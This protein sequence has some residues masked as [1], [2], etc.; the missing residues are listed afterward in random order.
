MHGG[1]IMLQSIAREVPNYSVG[2]DPSLTSFGVYLRPIDE[3][4]WYGFTAS[5]KSGSASDTHRV[6]G[7]HD[8]VKEACS[9]LEIKI[10]VFEDYGPVNVRAGKITARAE[11][12]GMLK[13]HFLQERRVPIIMVSPNSLKSFA[14]GKGNAKKEDMLRACSERGYFPE[15]ADEADAYWAACLGDRILTGGKIGVQFTRVNP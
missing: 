4:E 5:S 14:T 7:L 3:G 13:Q 6:L 2:F 1:N 10:A 15:S 11:M 8:E 9:G 12:C